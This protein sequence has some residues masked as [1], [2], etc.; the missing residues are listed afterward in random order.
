MVVRQKC[1]GAM[2][3]GSHRQKDIRLLN[4]A[5][6]IHVQCEKHELFVFVRC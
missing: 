5:R 3:R 6:S 1:H 2:L 4:L